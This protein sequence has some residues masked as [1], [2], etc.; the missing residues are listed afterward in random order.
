V[1]CI[2]ALKDELGI[3]IGS[4]ARV[5]SGQHYYSLSQP[6]Y[7]TKGDVTIAVSGYGWHSTVL[8]LNLAIPAHLPEIS[9]EEFIC[10]VLVKAIRQCLSDAGAY[11]AT[12]E[13]DDA[14]PLLI[15]YREHVFLGTTRNMHT[16]FFREFYSIGSGAPFANGSLYSTVGTPSED[17]VRMAL[18]AAAEF[19]TGVGG[20]F[21]VERISG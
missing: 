21:F 9:I 18:A 13:L 19:T 12:T 3:V 1:T 2:I 6:K 15:V 8:K 5:T 7:F 20:P 4:D 16:E 14:S 17:R 10:T 11:K